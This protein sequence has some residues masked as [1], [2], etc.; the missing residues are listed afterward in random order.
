MST[1]TVISSGLRSPSSTRMLADELAAAASAALPG[2]P[3]PRVIELRELVKDIGSALLDGFNPP[4]LQDALDAVS[5][6]DSLIVVTPTFQGSYAGLFKSFVDLLDATAL[7]RTPVLLA[8]TGGSERHSLVI[9]HAL[10]PLFSYLGAATVPTA[11]YAATQDFGAGTVA[12]EQRIERAAQELAALTSLHCARSTP[13]TGDDAL[14]EAQRSMSRAS[15][16]QIGDF[17]DLLRSLGQ[18]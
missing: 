9:D 12:L 3:T 4:A 5:T 11:V 15:G 14:G 2:A 6:T 13:A 8:A 7:R 1:L 16:E 10:R 17:G 18:A